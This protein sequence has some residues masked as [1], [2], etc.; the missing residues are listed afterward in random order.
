MTDKTFR[1]PIHW[2]SLAQ[3]HVGCVRDVNEDAILAKPEIGLWAVADGMG[4]HHVGDVAS[5]KI[6]AA[7]D[8]ITP[9]EN[10]C[11]TV[12]ALEDALLDINNNMLEYAQVMFEHGTMGSTLVSLLIKDRVGVCLWAGDSRLYRFRNQQLT[13]VT[14]DHSQLEEMLAAGLIAPEDEEHYP[15]KNVI[16]RAIGVEELLFIDATIFTA[17][18]GDIFLL[19]SDGLYNAVNLEEIT[20][21]FALRE[22]ELMVPHLVELALA[23]GA[24]DNVS[25]IAVLGSAGKLIGSATAQG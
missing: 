12:D 14:R 18:I 13:Q 19:C 8:A 5:S 15:H 4:G 16:T 21:A 25:V 10:L 20:A 22:P 1:R 11:D 23:K 24:K 7:L 17:Q 9:S 3:T 6:I 2:H